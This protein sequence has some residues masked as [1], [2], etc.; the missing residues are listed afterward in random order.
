MRLEFNS[1]KKRSLNFLTNLP[2][3]GGK[4]GH[5]LFCDISK[6]LIKLTIKNCRFA[7]GLEF[8]DSNLIIGPKSTGFAKKGMMFNVNMGIQDITNPKSTDKTDKT[9]AIFI[10]DTCVVNEVSLNLLF[11]KIDININFLI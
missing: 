1:L 5:Y 10:G 3:I 7:I 4:H 6:K 2:K 8:R 9:F 11:A